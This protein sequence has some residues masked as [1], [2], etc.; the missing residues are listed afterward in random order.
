MTFTKEQMEVLSQWEPNFKSAI[1]AKWS[2]GIGTTG[3]TTMHR[4]LTEA[5]GKHHPYSPSCG[6]CS[7]RLIQETG[8]LYFADK[9]EMEKAARKV[10]VTE[11]EAKPVKVP[12]KTKKPSTKKNGNK[13]N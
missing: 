2:R 10:E 12:V 11:A 6:S 3:Y 9:E 1:E 7:L 13:K 5:T 8:R 4:I